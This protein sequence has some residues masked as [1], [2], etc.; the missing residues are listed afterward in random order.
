MKIILILF[1]FISEINSQVKD[2]FEFGSK[3]ND[4]IASSFDKSNDKELNINQMD[5]IFSFALSIADSNIADAL[6]FCSIGT[7]TYPVFKIKLPYLNFFIPFS[8]FTEYDLEKMKKKEENL[9]HKLFEDSPDTKFGDKDKV[10][11]FFTFAYFSYLFG[12]SFAVHIGSFVEKFEESFKID[13]KVDERDLKINELGA[14]FG[15]E[16]NYKIIFPSFI[17]AKERSLTYGKNINN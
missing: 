6:L 9:P 10:V 13:G 12:Y 16:L 14:K 4:Y 7:M 2:I 5:S 1:L 8:V 15:Q 17:L 11:H 3:I